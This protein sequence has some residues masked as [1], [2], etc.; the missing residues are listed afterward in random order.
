VEDDYGRSLCLVE[1]QLHLRRRL[2][3]GMA[4]KE[5]LAEQFSR[6]NPRVPMRCGFDPLLPVSKTVMPLIS[7]LTGSNRDSRSLKWEGI[8]SPPPLRGFE[9]KVDWDYPQ[10]G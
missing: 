5:L 7:G 1:R 9:L 4:T 2:E 10:F 6:G 8:Y 3:R